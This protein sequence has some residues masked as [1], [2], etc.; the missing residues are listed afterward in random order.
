M[1]KKDASNASW[2]VS[3]ELWGQV[4]FFRA[5][6]QAGLQSYDEL[7]GIQWEWQ[8]VDGAMIK[9]LSGTPR[10]VPIRSIAASWE[11]SAVS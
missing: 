5:L 3:D 1:R 8:A 11:P 6:W 2:E 4:G 7:I 9:P 10:P